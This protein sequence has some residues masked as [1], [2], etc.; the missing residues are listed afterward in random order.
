MVTI[1]SHASPVTHSWREPSWC[2]IMPTIGRL[3]RLRRCAP[4]RGA[5]RTRP[6]APVDEVMTVLELFD[7]RYWDF[8]VKHLHETLV[9][10]HGF[11]R[12]YNWLRITL[13]ARRAE[14]L[15]SRRS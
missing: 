1:R 7:T 10:E 6:C 8:G 11:R 15:P 13:Q 4:R 3:D 14:T 9:A 2:S 5:G 12:S